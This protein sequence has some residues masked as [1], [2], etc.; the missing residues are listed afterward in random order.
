MDRVEVDQELAAQL[1]FLREIDA[2]KSV[3][4]RSQLMNGSRRENSAE[5]SW[6]VAMAAL[7]LSQYANEPV[8]VGRVVAML[9]VHDLV[10]IDAGDTFAYDTNG[11]ATQ[12][13]REAVAAERLY[14]LLPHEQRGD[15]VALWEEFE[16]QETAEA[17]F[18][19][20][21]DRLLPVMHN[22]ATA[23]GTWQGHHVDRGMVSRR[24]A[25]MRAGSER[26]WRYVEGL[27]DEAVARG[28]LAP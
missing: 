18:A 12:S 28:Y 6:H 5:H 16:A 17:K 21:L 1:A 3:Q 11:L 15:L 25:P 23:G 9:L 27:L 7:V 24:M 26:L 10:E 20:A 13:E 8:D 19:L 14:G 22:F 4:R 2:L